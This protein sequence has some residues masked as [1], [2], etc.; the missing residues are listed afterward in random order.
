MKPLEIKVRDKITAKENLFNYKRWFNG[1]KK[2][3]SLKVFT[4]KKSS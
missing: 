4:S 1:I 3:S 2:F